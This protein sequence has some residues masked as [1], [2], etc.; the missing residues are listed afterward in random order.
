MNSDQ[1][2]RRVV[3][4]FFLAEMAPFWVK[5]R[6]FAEVQCSPLAFNVFQG[7]P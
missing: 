2:T 4:F 1:T 7:N 6:N 3:Q 5:I